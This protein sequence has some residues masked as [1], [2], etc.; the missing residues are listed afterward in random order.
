MLLFSSNWSEG[1]EA[2]V[3][4]LY[5]YCWYSQNNYLTYIRV[6]ISPWPF[7]IR[8]IYVNV[9]D[10]THLR[11]FYCFGYDSKDKL[12][13]FEIQ[14]RHFDLKSQWWKTITASPSSFSRAPD[15]VYLLHSIHRIS[16]VEWNFLDLLGI[17]IGNL[18]TWSHFG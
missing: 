16:E 3:Q 4:K 11:K 13:H 1:R 5:N 18:E 17:Q 12:Y 10:L 9:N 14:G 6:N 8:T 7:Y 2:C 15:K